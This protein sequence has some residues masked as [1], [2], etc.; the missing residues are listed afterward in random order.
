MADIADLADKSIDAMIQRALLQAKQSAQP[1]IG[2][3]DCQE[4][5]EQ[6]PLERRALGY[7]V[8]VACARDAERQ[9]ALF[10]G[11]TSS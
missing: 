4:C 8:C 3:P 5:G 1:T 9:Q 7:S 6:I 2:A 10:A 11:A